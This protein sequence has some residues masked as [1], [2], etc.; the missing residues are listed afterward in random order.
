M[1]KIKT[2]KDVCDAYKKLPAD[3]KALV[4]GVM[5][6]LVWSSNKNTNEEE[7]DTGQTSTDQKGA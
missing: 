7:L 4:C 1:V 2:I 3:K 6:G 5:Q